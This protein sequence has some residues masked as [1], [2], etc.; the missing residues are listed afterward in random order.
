MGYVPKFNISDNTTVLLTDLFHYKD[1]LDYAKRHNLHVL[2]T[3]TTSTNSVEIISY[4]SDHGFSHEFIKE[5]VYSPEGLYLHDKILC[6]FFI[7][8]IVDITNTLG[9]TCLSCSNAF[10]EECNTGD[11]LFC[12]C[13]DCY[14]DEWG[15]C[16][17]WN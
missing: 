7:R 12:V 1:C 3:E 14:V 5:K 8:D 13:H 17:K 4:F 2:F 15:N 16:S 10:S 6:R 9:K 11:R